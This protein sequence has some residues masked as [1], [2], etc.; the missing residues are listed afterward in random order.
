MH[1][2]LIPFLWSSRRANGAA[3]HPLM[4]IAVVWRGGAARKAGLNTTSLL[5]QVELRCTRLKT[6]SAITLNFVSTY[7]YSNK[8]FIPC[9]AMLKAMLEVDTNWKSTRNLLI[10]PYMGFKIMHSW[11]GMLIKKCEKIIIFIYL[12]FMFLNLFSSLVL[13][14]FHFLMHMIRITFSGRRHGRCRRCSTIWTSD[15]TWEH[16]GKF[17]LVLILY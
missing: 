15:I 9:D 17:R 13:N 12:K 10:M 6:M 2:D 3:C 16:F 11:R 1:H 7:N 5:A 14:L 8:T 4:A